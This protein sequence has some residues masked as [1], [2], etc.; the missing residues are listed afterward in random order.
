MSDYRC[1][2]PLSTGNYLRM[3]DQAEPSEPWP[4]KPSVPQ[5][6]LQPAPCTEMAKMQMQ[7]DKRWDAVGERLLL[8][9]IIDGLLDALRTQGISLKSFITDMRAP[10][11]VRRTDDSYNI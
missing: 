5:D 8:L 3:Q 2:D 10:A 7:L 4:P 11:S 6:H 9:R 1:G